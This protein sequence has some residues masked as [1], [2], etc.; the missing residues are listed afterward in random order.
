M[1]MIFQCINIRQVPM[2]VLKT[3]A[4]G[5]GFQH[6]PRNPANVNAWKTMSG[7]YNKTPTEIHERLCLCRLRPD[8]AF[9]RVQ[10]GQNTHRLPLI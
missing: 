10:S 4:S 5:F 7:P 1:N 6:F 8:S 2:E 9:S 3:A